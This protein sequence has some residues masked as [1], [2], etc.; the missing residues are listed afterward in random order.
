MNF[1]GLLIFYKD[2]LRNK[3]KQFRNAW[4]EKS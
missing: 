1:E 2:D 3:K 4:W